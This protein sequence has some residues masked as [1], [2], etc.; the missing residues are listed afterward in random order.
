[1][2]FNLRIEESEM[3][4]KRNLVIVGIK[5]PETT[6]ILSPNAKLVMK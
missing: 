4:R 2:T 1:M 5:L 3:E 6:D